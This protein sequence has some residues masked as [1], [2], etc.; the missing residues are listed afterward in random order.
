MPT[1]LPSVSTF[2]AP[3]VVAPVDPERNPTQAV[4]YW[5]RRDIA[6]GVFE[7]LERLKVEHLT[8]FYDIGHS[9]IREAIVLLV[10]SGL[11][12]HEHQ[13]GYRAAPVS[14]E[15]YQDL[16]TVYQRIYKMMLGMAMERGDDAWEEQVV[17]QLHRSLKIPK[18]VDGTL[19][20]QAREMWQRSYGDLHQT[21]LSGCRSALLMKIYKDIGARL[22]RYINL[23][24]DLETDRYYDHHADHRLIVDAIIA[25]DADR[26]QA[27]IERYFAVAEPIRKSIIAALKAMEATPSKAEARDIETAPRPAKSSKTP[28][29]RRS[30]RVS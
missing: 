15:D 16:L 6:R 21:L 7:P 3:N 5:L 17:I 29:A 4:A 1:K 30:A 10:D 20:P 22:E 19:D 14:L 26:T 13:K 11:V 12:I 25:R 24:A 2:T 18:V 8:K 9:P 27:L 23:F 28:A